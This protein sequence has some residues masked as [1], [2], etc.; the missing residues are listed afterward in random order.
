MRKHILDEY[1]GNHLVARTNPEVMA[2][3]QTCNYQRS[4]KSLNLL[5]PDLGQGS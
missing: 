5:L 3:T 1:K 2:K 4:E